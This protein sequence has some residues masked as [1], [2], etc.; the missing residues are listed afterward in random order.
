MEWCGGR[1]STWKEN[2]RMKDRRNYMKQKRRKGWRVRGGG[3]VDEAR[4]RQGIIGW[5]KREAGRTGEG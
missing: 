3:E 5:G 4:K 1:W 2:E